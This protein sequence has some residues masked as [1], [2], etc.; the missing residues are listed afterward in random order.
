MTHEQTNHLMLLPDSSAAAAAAAERG[1]AARDGEQSRAEAATKA[2][3]EHSWIGSSS[4]DPRLNLFLLCSSRVCV[5]VLAFAKLLWLRL[6]PLPR[7]QKIHQTTRG[8]K[9]TDT[10][11]TPSPTRGRGQTRD[12][13]E[14]DADSAGGCRLSALLLSAS[15]V[16][17]GGRTNTNRQTEKQ[18][19]QTHKRNRTA[20][21]DATMQ[22]ER[23]WRPTARR[24]RVADSQVDRAAQRQHTFAQ[25]L[26]CL[27][28]QPAL[29]E[30]NPSSIDMRDWRRRGG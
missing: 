27:S 1:C 18:R 19:T 21:G 16:R 26:T 20:A 12:A 10:S 28:S 15:G 25:R 8:K 13:A 2:E 7:R 3:H 29:V 11:R 4:Q 17:I 23:R 30:Q 24:R 9:S 22:A 14:S 5:S 6:R